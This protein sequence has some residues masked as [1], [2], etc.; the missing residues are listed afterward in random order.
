MEKKSKKGSRY[1]SDSLDFKAEFVTRAGLTSAENHVQPLKLP[2][3]QRYYC[4]REQLVAGR[5]SRQVQTG[6]AHH[7][8]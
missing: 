7:A 2:V 6:R 4:K 3:K 8:P 5:H 1:R